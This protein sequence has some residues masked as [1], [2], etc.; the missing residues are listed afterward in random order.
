MTSPLKPSP[1]RR[2]ALVDGKFITISAPIKT[3]AEIPKKGKKSP[4]P[5]PMKRCPPTKETVIVKGVTKC[6]MP[7]KPGQVRN[8]T[9]LRC[10]KE[11]QTPKPP[12][13]KRC[14][15]TKE[16]VIVK[17]VTKCYVPCKRSQVRSPTSLRC[18]KRRGFK[19]PKPPPLR[20]KTTLTE[21]IQHCK[22]NNTFHTL[23]C[24][25]L[26]LKEAFDILKIPC[27]E[28]SVNAINKG[29]RMM[30]L[31]THPDKCRG[32]PNASARFLKINNAKDLLIS[33]NCR[34]ATF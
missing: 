6:Y 20:K 22:F 29:Y 5:P 2:K 28:H 24:P 26:N 16:T 9:S 14:P 1:L 30:A 25:P 7:C 19:S 11:K 34:L 4:N 15:P 8:P 33:P 10:G 21:T 13:I 32:D 3:K 31:A 17:G 18:A 27:E 23:K 12:P